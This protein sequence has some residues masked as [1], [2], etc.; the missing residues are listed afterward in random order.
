MNNPQLILLLILLSLHIS[1]L[2]V[3]RTYSYVPNTE[4]WKE[5]ATRRFD[6]ALFVNTTQDKYN[7]WV[8]AVAS[9]YTQPNF[10]ET[11]WGVTRAPPE[12]VE[13]LRSAVREAYEAGDYIL[14]RESAA[15]D[16]I[17]RPIF[18]DRP[19]LTQRVV[20]ELRPHHEAWAGIPLEPFNAYGFRLYQNQSKLYM[21]I[22]N[23]QTHVISSILHIDSSDDA[24]DWPLVMEDY[25]GNTNEII[26]T[27]GDMLFYESSKCFHGRPHTFNGSWYSS[28]FIHY[29]PANHPDWS[30][31]YA[32]RQQEAHFGVPP[33]WDSA[34]G[35]EARLP[36]LELRA[37]AVLEP[38][39]DHQ[40]CGLKDTVSWRGPAEL[41]QV[42]TA[43][44]TKY[45]LWRRRRDEL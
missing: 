9:A 45:P 15:I 11:G 20:T 28:V 41:D 7:M 35:W 6:Q 31:D 36:Q 32:N 38:E 19:D 16:G 18:I 1:S 13:T 25:L 5:L 29:Y 34:P 43:E 37:A 12:L 4:G 21:H 27:P 22:D 39:C 30:T 3:S 33:V 44:A 40:W 10:T 42:V 26:L 2:A 23:L 8:S 14:E 24:D 17:D